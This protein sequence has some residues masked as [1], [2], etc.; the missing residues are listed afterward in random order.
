M[1]RFMLFVAGLALLAGVA[2]TVSGGATQATT[3]WVTTDL[4]TLGGPSS[5]A[6]AINQR[7]QVVGYS[8]VVTPD[9]R[10]R[11]HAFLWENGKMRDL[12][13]LPGNRYSEATDI[14]ERGQI[15]GR[16]WNTAD[17]LSDEGR[18]FLWENGKMRDLGSLGDNYGE[19][20]R[21]NDR[22][23]VLA[24]RCGTAEN[25]YTEPEGDKCHAFLWENGK[26]RNLGGRW[27]WATGLNERGQVIG[28]SA[29]AM[30]EDAPIWHAFLWQNGK[31]RDLS[32]PRAKESAAVAINE[33]GQI[34]GCSGSIDYEWDACSENEDGTALVWQNG[35]MRKLGTLGGKESQAE[36]INDRGQMVGGSDTAGNKWHPVLWENGKMRDL[37]ALPGNRDS[38]ATN[39]NERGQVIGNCGDY[40]WQKCHAFLWQDGKLRSIG[41]LPGGRYSEAVA[42]NDRGQ[43]AGDSE[44]GHQDARGS[45]IWHAVLWTLRRG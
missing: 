33:R 16:T 23:Q 18:A 31:S 2:A 28:M 34:V 27:S 43:I 26:M 15:V 13:T 20:V 3:R 19:G 9:G 40:Y 38:V 4:G 8:P 39:I 45:P 10:L 42:I 32:A 30:G 21:I 44:T 17:L 35:T 14:N 11:R 22:G 1:R 6:A 5:Y 7:G 41:T 36:D 12:G 29:N 24:T 37:G 25:W